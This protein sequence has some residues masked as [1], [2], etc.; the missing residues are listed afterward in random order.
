[1]RFP[2]TIVDDRPF[3]KIC[4]IMKQMDI[5]HL[6][7]YTPYLFNLYPLKLFALIQTQIKYHQNTVILSSVNSYKLHFFKFV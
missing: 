5:P 6:S 3:T 2:L 4:S 1:M 7:N